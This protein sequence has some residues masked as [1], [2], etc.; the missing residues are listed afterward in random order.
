MLNGLLL[1]PGIPGL[2]LVAEWRDD[3][4]STALPSSLLPPWFGKD[5]VRIALT[6]LSLDEV[7]LLLQQIL[8]MPAESAGILAEALATHTDGN[9][10]YTVELINALREGGVLLATDDGWTWD[11]EKLR[12]YVGSSSIA[13]LLN[14]RLGRLPAEARALLEVM[15][16]LGGHV[17]GTV[18]AAASGVT[19]TAMAESLAPA[20]EEGLLTMDAHIDDAAVIGFPHERVQQAAYEA[21]EP[22]VRMSLRLSI[23][24]RLDGVTDAMPLA[25]ALYMPLAKTLDATER[26]RAVA[27]FRQAAAA[28]TDAGESECLLRRA[29]ESMPQSGADER[30]MTDTIRRELHATLLRLGR[31]EEADALFEVIDAS[32]M[33]A[34][35]LAHAA[36]LQ[37]SS[38]LVR[39]RTPEGLA[40]GMRMLEKLG[41]A[42][43][44]LERPALQEQLSEF[45]H[46]LEGTAASDPLALPEVSSPRVRVIVMLLERCASAAFTAD[47]QLLGSIV[48]SVWR[49][50]RDEGV[51]A[52]MIGAL[53][54]V[55]MV[56]SQVRNDYRLGYAAVHYLLALAT[57]RGYTLEGARVRWLLAATYGHWF[58][59]VEHCVSHGRQAHEVMMQ[60]GDLLATLPLIPVV[61]GTFEIAPTL[62][63]TE[64]E[65]NA[66]LDV[67]LRS[68]SFT[69]VPYFHDML[70]L[71]RTLQG[72]QAGQPPS[73][74][75]IAPTPITYFNQEFALALQGALMADG[76][77]LAVHAET[78]YAAR[79]VLHGAYKTA[80]AIVL[81]AVGQ[82]QRAQSAEPGHR[83]TLLARARHCRDELTQGALGA[84]S[85]FAHLVAWVDAECAWAEAAYV[86][87]IQA[88]DDALCRLE[89]Q[90]RPW[91]RALIT[92]RAG[93]FHL[94]HGMR[95]IG[96]RLLS[97]A[98]RY[99]LAWGAVS[100]VVQLEHSYPFLAQ[101]EKQLPAE[102]LRRDSVSA[103]SFDLLGLL[104]ASQALSSETSLDRLHQRVVEQ[105]E[106]MTGAT[107]VQLVLL[108]DGG[109]SALVRV[110]DEGATQVA[111]EEAAAAGLL[112]MSAVRYVERTY[113]PLAIDDAR[114]D[115]RFAAD[116]YL[117][118]MAQCSL[119]LLPVLNQGAL[120]AVLVL[121][122][123]QRQGAFCGARMQAVLLIAGQLAVSLDN[124]M[125]YASLEKKVAQRTEELE[126]ANREL[127]ALSVTDALTG[128]ANRRR[129]NETLDVEW[130][131]TM[132]Q[133]IPL[134]AAMIDVDQF[135]LY[136]D[137]HGH[138]QGD[139]CLK[140]VAEVMSRHVRH[141][142]DLAARYGGE[143]F[144]LIL[145]GADII[146]AHAVAERIRI[147][148]EALQIPHPSSRHGIVTISVGIA[149]LMPGRDVSS[150]TLFGA[151]DAALYGAKKAG[152][153][154][155][156]VAE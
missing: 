70:A 15:A 32:E 148:V 119:L 68:G 75:A 28:S 128:L 26:L 13:S 25:A 90:Q 63:A 29:L 151:A 18:L 46:W 81:H 53:A 149:S 137:N 133:D 153:N 6:N 101:G 121:E 23:A 35:E 31:N 80:L 129:F 56:A 39:R 141:G 85:N 122:N 98:C 62:S 105:L 7:G 111:I 99:Y 34:V 117:Q 95:W 55:G 9:P 136:N 97:D 3:D 150:A 76:E 152:R 130:L 131:R 140:R 104:R 84:P 40:L 17:R 52:P 36:C 114:T 1:S 77:R 106:A 14:A 60:G 50:W 118:A 67:A 2:L 132:R 125:L 38:L 41:F 49:L 33:P 65:A 146:E 8:R 116:P 54:Y 88:F 147:A 37:L 91:H 10:Y 82:A 19:P 5:A 16:C 138:Q 109:R 43:D 79:N 115:D 107:H 44:R 21:I 123:R 142:V 135:K 87:A 127:A 27:L 86:D 71:A 126:K 139:V 102:G 74:N 66:A 155:V 78:A 30:A 89:G 124:A 42:L 4:V 156:N 11:A 69:A 143:E 58:E 47:G 92:E 134:G 64:A 108:Q 72:H 51:Y 154:R 12:R 57:A 45:E 22:S 93:L 100:K 48:F 120:R 113:L 83:P 24:R 144:A 112:P 61:S 96:R 103:D 94:A 20:L 73:T 110:G 59:P 145:P